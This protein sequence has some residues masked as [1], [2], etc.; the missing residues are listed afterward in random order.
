MLDQIHPAVLGPGAARP[1][2]GDL[3]G[4]L[5]AAVDRAE[6]PAAGKERDVLIRASR[7]PVHAPDADIRSQRAGDNFRLRGVRGRAADLRLRGKSL[8]DKAWA[9]RFEDI[10]PT[11]LVDGQESRALFA[12]EPALA[13]GAAQAL[14]PVG[15]GLAIG[16]D[17]HLEGL[18]LV[19]FRGPYTGEIPFDV[20]RGVRGRIRS[21]RDRAVERRGRNFRGTATE[22]ERQQQNGQD[23]H[24]ASVRDRCGKKQP[25]SACDRPVFPAC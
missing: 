9:G 23:P 14:G 12:P 17:H 11:I 24:R 7:F 22:N 2:F 18:A 16:K 15:D 19:V 8:V 1:L 3:P 4:T 20:R 21:N 10:G 13:L 25:F 6:G 5:R